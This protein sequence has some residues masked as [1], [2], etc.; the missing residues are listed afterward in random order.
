MQIAGKKEV[1]GPN[2]LV[3]YRPEEPQSY[4]QLDNESSTFFVHFT[5]G[6]IEQLLEKYHVTGPKITFKEEFK[7]MDFTCE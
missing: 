1:L 6:Q 7:K 5:G 2:S 3:L 4:Q